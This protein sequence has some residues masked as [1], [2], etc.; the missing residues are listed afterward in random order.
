MPQTGS[1][2]FI[3]VS[4]YSLASPLLYKEGFGWSLLPLPR[5]EP[6]NFQNFLGDRSVFV[7]HGGSLDSFR[8][9][10][11]HAGKTGHIIRWLKLQD[12]GYQ[13]NFWEGEGG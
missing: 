4:S 11:G 9:E 12:R 10:I 1:S 5:R 6:I 7:I 13:V 3:R 2:L 8:M